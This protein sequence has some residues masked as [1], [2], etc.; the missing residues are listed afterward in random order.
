MNAYQKLLENKDSIESLLSV[1]ID[2]TSFES[3]E[4]AYWFTKCIYS[5]DDPAYDQKVINGFDIAF[6]LGLNIEVDRDKFLE[7]TR[8]T[9]LLYFKYNQY[10]LA[11]NKLLMLILSGDE[12]PV[13]V[14]LYFAITQIYTN[15]S[16]VA[17]DPDYYLFPYLDVAAT[18]EDLTRRNLI[19]IDFLNR[20]VEKKDSD[21]IESIEST[22]I[23]E[24]A[25]EYHLNTEKALLY[26]KN[27]FNI[28]AET[29]IELE[30]SEE[31]PEKIDAL[32][33]HQK[34]LI[35]ANE[36]IAALESKVEELYKALE[37]KEV[38]IEEKNKLIQAS[39]GVP[40]KTSEE[41]PLQQDQDDV[42]AIAVAI[43][44][45][46]NDLEKLIPQQT[47]PNAKEL[48][49]RRKILVYG[50]QQSKQDQLVLHAKKVFG[51]TEDCFDF[52]LDYERIKTHAERV[53]PFSDKYAGVLIGE[54][55][56]KTTGTADYSSLITKF[57]NE[58]GYPY[59]VRVMTESH[60]LKI[61]KTSFGKALWKLLY[62]L[63]SQA[64]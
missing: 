38:A 56:H 11:S 2:P 32:E 62:H 43:E 6:Y 9:A 59:P 23:F 57:E 30:S 8:V 25:C 13:W 39:L 35:A 15:L 14:N 1:K 19:Y 10:A 37:E 12:I 60:K 54:C 58:E 51:L 48:L 34:E 40:D 46:E 18:D 36:R 21:Y 49:R 42:E 28:T 22:I 17:E 29:P 47:F 52:V 31:S 27:A 55:P 16:L 33:K 45:A 63:Q 44:E 24:K 61:T 41:K 4:D 53:Q 64:D 3:W 50:G 20:L 5:V 7:A 26:F